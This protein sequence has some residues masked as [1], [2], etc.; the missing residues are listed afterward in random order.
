MGK[1]LKMA[2]SESFGWMSKMDIQYESGK[3]R[4]DTIQTL[5]LNKRQSIAV[6]S[7]L[8]V[9]LLMKVIDRLE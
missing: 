4:V 1:V 7:V 2:E 3:G 8:D 6:A 9:S 5:V